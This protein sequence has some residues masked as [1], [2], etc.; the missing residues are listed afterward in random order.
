MDLPSTLFR[1][2]PELPEVIAYSDNFGNM[3]TS[4]LFRGQFKPGQ[5]LSVR[6][7]EGP[8]LQAKFYSRLV[9]VPDGELAVDVGSSGLGNLRFLE[10]VVHGVKSGSAASRLS[11]PLAGTRI[12]I[13]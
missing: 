3:K 12:E 10:I 5:A 1:G 13:K 9:D 6:V 4:I 7:G 11:N 8:C 2:V